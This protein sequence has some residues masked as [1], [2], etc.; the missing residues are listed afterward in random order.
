M[1]I[2]QFL[3]SQFLGEENKSKIQ[4][5][6]KLL[7]DNSFNLRKV[8]Q[9]VNPEMIIG[10]IKDFMKENKSR[11]ETVR[12]NFGVSPISNIANKDIV[13]NLN[14]YFASN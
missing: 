8:M 5:I 7:Q 3:L 11:T 6:L 13:Y 2:L 9:N 1:E 4:P 14:K 10:L 12:Q